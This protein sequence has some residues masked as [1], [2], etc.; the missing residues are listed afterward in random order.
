MSV[1]TRRPAAAQR[2]AAPRHG[3]RTLRLASWLVIVPVL[4]LFSF[5]VV[6]GAAGFGAVPRYADAAAKVAPAGGH[7]K[8][9]FVVVDSSTADAS[10]SLR[11]LFRPPAGR[12]VCWIT[13]TQLARVSARYETGRMSISFDGS[14]LDLVTVGGATD[15]DLRALLGHDVECRLVKVAHLFFLPFDAQGS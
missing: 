6:A 12:E 1:D 2:T 8:G 11:R 10:N 13:T 7:E 3:A 5:T 14:T 15:G 4:A 9:G